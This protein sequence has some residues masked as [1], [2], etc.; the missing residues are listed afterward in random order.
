MNLLAENS[1][2]SNFADATHSMT[3]SDNKEISK[4]RFGNFVNSE[5]FQ[6][7]ISKKMWLIDGKGKDVPQPI[8]LSG[9]PIKFHFRGKMPWLFSKTEIDYYLKKT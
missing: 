2:L 3:I 5:L 1:M 7:T 6:E 9:C 8:W 4:L